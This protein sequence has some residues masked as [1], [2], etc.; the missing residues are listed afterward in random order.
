MNYVG[1][2][3]VGGI[4]GYYVGAKHLLGIQ[5]DKNINTQQEPSK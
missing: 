3:A 5:T 1:T 2:G 4:A